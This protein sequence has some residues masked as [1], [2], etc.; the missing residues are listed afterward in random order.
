[1]AGMYFED[2]EPGR[3]FRHELSRTI[4]LPDS[5]QYALM[6]METEPTYLDEEWA[7]KFSRFHRIEVYPLYVLSI[8]MAVQVPDLTLGTTL[9]NLSMGDVTFPHPVFPNDSIR[10]QTT[11]VGKTESKSRADRGVVD[12]IHEGFNQKDQ[13][14]MRCSR[15]GMM[16]RRPVGATISA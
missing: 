3:V 1:M 13:L 9:G 8:V 4:T 6:C 2:F 11:I 12:F 10:G 5:I 16:L 15:K 7:R 14:V